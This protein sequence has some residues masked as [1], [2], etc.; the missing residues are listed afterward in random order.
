MEKIRAFLK[1]WW[2][3]PASLLVWYYPIMPFG[4]VIWSLIGLATGSEYICTIISTLGIGAMSSLPIILKLRKIDTMKKSTKYVL[5]A[6][7]VSAFALLT[8][9]ITIVEM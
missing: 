5:G 9:Y 4:L 3:V 2:V 6:V 7:S 1:E 8:F